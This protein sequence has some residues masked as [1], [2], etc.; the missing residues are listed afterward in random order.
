MRRRGR[1]RLLFIV[2]TAALVV[3]PGFVPGARPAAAAEPVRV[4][5]YNVCGAICNGGVVTKPGSDNDVVEDVRNRIVAARP[6]IVTLN[7]VCNGQFARLKNV[8]QGSHWP[9]DGVFRKQRNDGR[10]KDGSGFGDAVLTAGPVGRTEV[11]QLPDRG[12][13]DR[14]I[15]CLN[16]SAHGPVLACSLHLVTG[17]NDG[18]Q[19]RLEQLAA[20]ARALNRRAGVR[21]VIVGGDFNTVPSGMGALLDPRR[22]GRFFDV[23][24]QKAP[25]RGS[26]IDYVLFSRRHFSDPSG[27]PV[28]S[29]FSDHEVLVGRATRR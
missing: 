14:A 12:S 22:G 24:P 6:H 28:S 2:G 25:T 17:K 7:E 26:K 23:D 21:A 10:C 5:Q 19:E 27:G 29:R 11:L 13:E 1:A 9:M 16:T 15:I 3:N 18:R 20:A 8:L 4:M